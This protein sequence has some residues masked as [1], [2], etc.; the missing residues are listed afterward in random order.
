MEPWY[1]ID[2][3]LAT[4]RSMMDSVVFIFVII[5]FLVLA[6][7][8]VNTLVMAVYERVREIGLM[9]ALGVSPK[10][11]MAQILAEA[12][13]LLGVGLALGNLAAW[14]AILPIR[15]GLDLSFIAEGLAD[16]GAGATLVPSLRL[17]DVVTANVL[18]LVLGF[19][20]SLSPAW[21]AS[22]LE[23]VEAISKT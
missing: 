11:I 20:A 2:T 12:V 21:R 8:L 15:D 13:L 7:G 9:L 6:F 10:N 3:Y 18:V 23:P 5:I 4:M 17:Q 22:R 16:M 1:E 19:V 14:L